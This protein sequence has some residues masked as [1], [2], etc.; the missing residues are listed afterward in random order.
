MALLSYSASSSTPWVLIKV[1]VARNRVEIRVALL[2]I[3]VQ[4]ADGQL[5][6]LVLLIL[7]QT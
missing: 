4:V 7:P 5:I 3:G 1:C 6:G 2:Q